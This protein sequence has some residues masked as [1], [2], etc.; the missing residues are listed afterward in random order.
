MRGIHILSA[1]I[2]HQLGKI[3]GDDVCSEGAVDSG[4]ELVVGLLRLKTANQP[5]HE[6]RLAGMVI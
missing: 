3:L 6:S 4:D 1:H 2:A 5:G